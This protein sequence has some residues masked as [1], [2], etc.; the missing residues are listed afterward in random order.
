[1][2]LVLGKMEILY[3]GDWLYAKGH[4]D[5]QEFAGEVNAQYDAGAYEEEV[6]HTFLRCIPARPGDDHD[7]LLYRTAPGRGAFAATL[8]DRS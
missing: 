5:K 4:V 6:E 7:I 1:L 8:L 2:R 3:A